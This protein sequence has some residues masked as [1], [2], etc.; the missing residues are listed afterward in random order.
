VRNA[1]TA[2]ASRHAVPASPASDDGAG[3]EGADELDDGVD[4][5]LIRWMLE[6]A[7]AERLAA[8]QGFV[9]SVLSLRDGADG[10]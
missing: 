8:L 9:D 10:P 6:L 2:W 1:P 5:S 7:P 3:P 4:L